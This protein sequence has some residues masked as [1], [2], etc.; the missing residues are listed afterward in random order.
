METF[1]CY[2]HF[3]FAYILRIIRKSEGSDGKNEKV[4]LVEE[5]TP[6]GSWTFGVW[7][8]IFSSVCLEVIISE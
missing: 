6:N 5:K 7:V 8:R 3:L 4:L 1:S 2:H